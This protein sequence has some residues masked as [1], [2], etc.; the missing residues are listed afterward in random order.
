MMILAVD[1]RVAADVLAR[2]REVGGMSDL[3][4][5]ELGSLGS[6]DSDR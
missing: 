1:D 5:V 4:Y 2:L 6:K 3:K